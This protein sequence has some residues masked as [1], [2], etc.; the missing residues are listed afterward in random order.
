MSHLFDTDSE[1]IEDPE[2]YASTLLKEGERLVL[3]RS[4]RKSNPQHPE[5][6]EGSKGRLPALGIFGW[7]LFM[8]SFEPFLKHQHK[9][10]QSVAGER[11][12]GL[13][14]GLSVGKKVKKNKNNHQM[15]QKHQN[16]QFH[17]D[18]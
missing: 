4:R 7:I 18:K 16:H 6:I 15:H 14:V 12:G 13:S 3:R 10:P 8:V 1:T 2:S 17:Q 11:A 5:F 9:Y